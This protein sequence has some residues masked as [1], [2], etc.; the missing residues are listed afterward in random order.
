MCHPFLLI[1]KLELALT[2]T[3]NRLLIKLLDSLDLILVLLGRQ[4]KEWKQYV[5]WHNAGA[6]VCYTLYKVYL[7]FISL[8]QLLLNGYRNFVINAVD[9]SL[10][11]TLFGKDYARLIGLLT[12]RAGGVRNGHESLLFDGHTVIELAIN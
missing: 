1:H 2:D 10:V 9:A 4:V 12:N 7:D 3:A 11:Q 5:N 8:V 6:P